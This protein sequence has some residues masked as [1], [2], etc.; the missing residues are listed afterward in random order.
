MLK[1]LNCSSLVSTSLEF[2]E[3][4]LLPFNHRLAV[5]LHLY[6]TKLKYR[7]LHLV[8]DSTSAPISW[9]LNEQAVGYK[10]PRLSGLKNKN[11]RSL[12][13]LRDEYI[14]YLVQFRDYNKADENEVAQQAWRI[15]KRSLLTKSNTKKEI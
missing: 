6:N 3:N 8:Y 7:N 14:Y 11:L 1:L 15:W 13:K 10:L 4:S 9:L 5:R 2:R 12:I